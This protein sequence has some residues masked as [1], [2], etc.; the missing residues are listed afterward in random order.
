MKKLIWMLCWISIVMGEEIYFQHAS[1]EVLDQKS[2]FAVEMG[3]DFIET[4]VTKMVQQYADVFNERWNGERESPQWRTWTSSKDFTMQHPH[5][6]SSRFNL[7]F[8]SAH[9]RKFFGDW[10]P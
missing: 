10:I 2:C 7:R 4:A 6:E 8:D 9:R 3:F 5:V 1:D